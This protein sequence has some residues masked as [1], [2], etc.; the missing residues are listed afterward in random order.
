MRKVVGGGLVA[1]LLLSVSVMGATRLSV[2]A[3]PWGGVYFFVGTALAS[4]L[5]KHMPAVDAK[6]VPVT[7]GVHGLELLH[8]GEL[9]IALVGLSAA[10]FGV[11]GERE[12]DRKY[13]NVGFV[14]AA[15]DTGQSLITLADSGIKT[16]ADVKGLRVAANTSSSKA[17][18]LA[19]LKPYGVNESDFKLSLM[20]YA[21]Q[22]AALR[23]GT[24]DAAFIALSPRNSDVADFAAQQSIRI[25]GFEPAK[26]KLFEAYPYW[27]P[28]VLK[29]R[30]YPGQDH[31]L[32][33]P[34]AH[35]TLLAY[36]QADPA[37]IYEIVRTI[38][39]RGAEFVELHPGAR[40]FTV[41]KTRDFVERRLVPMAFHP[42]A[43]RYWREKGVLK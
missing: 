16:F 39:E 6:A 20:N 2:G 22:I 15:M 25:V 9:T 30:T 3:G 8:K 36:K 27:T 24:I 19:A 34:G 4:L 21:G 35:T 11:R 18:L 13:D 33:V 38:I 42:G 43:A 41:E 37:L 31:D 10:H 40:E 12:F 28:I 29:T 17:E 32:L 7:G 26:A 1:T 5:S 23:E 14:M